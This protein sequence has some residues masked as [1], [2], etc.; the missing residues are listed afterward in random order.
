MNAT[1]R[2]KPAKEAP[3]PVEDQIHDKPDNILACRDM[4][5][6]WAIDLPYYGVSIEGGV[7]GALYVERRAG[8]MRCNTQRIELYRVHKNRLERLSTKYVYP[9][10]YHIRGAK[11][12]DDVVGKARFEQYRR[13]QPKV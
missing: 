4:R 6:A 8:C 12:G 5:H 11:R 3:A 13:S 7:R 2:R 9:E 10:E 1:K